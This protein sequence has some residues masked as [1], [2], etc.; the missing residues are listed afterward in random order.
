MKLRLVAAVVV[1]ALSSIAAHA[2]A[3]VYFTA[4]IYNH[5]SNS[6]ADTGPF[7]FLGNGKTANS[8]WGV[9]F[10]GYYEVPVNAKIN[11]GIDIHDSIVRGNNA[12]LNTFMVGVRVSGKPFTRRPIK[13]YVEVGVGAGTSRPPTG[14]LK[15]TKPQYGVFA[16]AE[17]PLSKHVDWRVI[18]IGWNSVTTVSNETVGGTA[19]IPSATIISAS[20]GLVFRFK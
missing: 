12:S 18:E 6:V 3:A 1:L 15:V 17:Y 19:S 5:I 9:G 16:G 7:A 14:S 11:A 2:Q 10:G 8:F 4:P 13:P 20:S